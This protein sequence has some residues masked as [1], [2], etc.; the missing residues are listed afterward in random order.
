MATETRVSEFRTVIE[1]DPEPVPSEERE[2]LAALDEAKRQNGLEST[3]PAGGSEVVRSASM[4]SDPGSRSGS[5]SRSLSR[6]SS[7]NNRS[8]KEMLVLK[9]QAVGALPRGASQ[10]DDEL[11]G[12][13]EKAGIAPSEGGEVH[14][15]I[16][17]DKDPVP[18][19]EE[20]RRAAV[21]EGQGKKG[22]GAR[23]KDKFAG[24][25]GGRGGERKAGDVKPASGG[26]E[27]SVS[28]RLLAWKKDH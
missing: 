10:D 23:I 13:I 17:G 14:E 9:G 6:S 28:F 4:E 7:S 21:A 5:S 18:E 26:K 20:E 27:D 3:P 16:E 11:G 8:K 25:F 1:G 15:S 12:V 24:L 19:Q 2:R 22:V